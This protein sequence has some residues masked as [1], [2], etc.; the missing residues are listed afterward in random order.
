MTLPAELATALAYEGLRVTPT[1]DGR[2]LARRA[3]AIEATLRAALGELPPS[4]AGALRYFTTYVTP[5][6][7]GDPHVFWKPA[8]MI[9][10]SPDFGMLVDGPTVA[11]LDGMRGVIESHRFHALPAVGEMIAPRAHLAAGDRV[12]RARFTPRRN[13]LATTLRPRRARHAHYTA[14]RLRLICRL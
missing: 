1:M 6:A 13:E 9:A 3:E 14:A 4:A 8:T 2:T 5:H 12:V 7:G 11:G 10:T